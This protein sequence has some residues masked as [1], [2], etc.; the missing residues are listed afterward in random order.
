MRRNIFLGVANKTISGYFYAQI[1][2][3]WRLILMN[4]ELFELNGVKEVAETLMKCLETERLNLLP[5]QA[6]SLS[7]SLVDYSKMQMELGLKVNKAILD[8]EEMQYAMKVRLTKVLENIDNYLWFTNWAIVLKE[9]KLIIGY[10]I[11]KGLPN[12]LGEVIVGYDIDEK[13]RRKGYAKEALGKMLQWIFT[14][15]RALS[16]IA[17]TEKTNI[18]SCK[19]LEHIGAVPYKETDELIWWKINKHK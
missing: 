9:E 12:E 7:L 15:P 14:N 8:D 3:L 2:K 19:L 13:Y 18:P 1:L 11:L 4:N 17:D 10:I 16:V 6:H 5:L